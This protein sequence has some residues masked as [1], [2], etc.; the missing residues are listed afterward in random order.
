MNDHDVY[1]LIGIDPHELAASDE[2][3]RVAWEAG[4][5]GR[6]P[7]E[8][9]E[10]ASSWPGWPRCECVGCGCDQPATTTD[11]ASVPV[12]DDCAYYTVTDD[13]DVLCSRCEGTEYVTETCGAGGQTRTY[14]RQSPP[15]E[16]PSDPDGE[17]ACYWETVDGGRLVSRHA[18]R[19]QAEQAV[20]AKDWPPPWD[21]TQYLCGYGVRRLVDDEW[22]PVDDE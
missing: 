20:R 10:L 13:G 15:E 3:G 21:H 7:D 16:P 1:E 2:P 11:D 9:I 18:T 8:L 12:C 19:E 17:W 22:V 14:L 5:G 4:R 6:R